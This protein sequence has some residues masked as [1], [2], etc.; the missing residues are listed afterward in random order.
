MCIYQV[1]KIL[2]MFYT[3]TIH[4]AD[5]TTKHNGPVV[6]ISILLM[7]YVCML[8]RGRIL[9]CKIATAGF[10]AIL[11]I[12]GCDRLPSWSC[13]VTLLKNNHEQMT[14]SHIDCRQILKGKFDC[15]LVVLHVVR[16][17]HMGI[18]LVTSESPKSATQNTT[19]WGHI[20]TLCSLRWFWS[21]ASNIHTSLPSKC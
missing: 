21:F 18:D 15:S 11:L 1:C 4:L 6:K 16:S 17:V 7:A 8:Y 20:S 5:N 13:D 19:T 9:T 3:N 2:Y 12:M 10:Q 14:W